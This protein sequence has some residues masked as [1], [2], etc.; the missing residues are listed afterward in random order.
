MGQ[1]K[2]RGTFAQRQGLA[3]AKLEAR[4]AYL[5]EQFDKFQRGLNAEKLEQSLAVRKLIAAKLG[6][7]IF[8]PLTLDELADLPWGEVNQVLEAPADYVSRGGS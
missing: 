8:V 1:A 7:E 3:V 4:M 6:V 2:A 5:R